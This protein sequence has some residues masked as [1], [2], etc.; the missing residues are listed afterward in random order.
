[1]HEKSESTAGVLRQ[2]AQLLQ[3]VDAN[4][5]DAA[6]RAGRHLVCRP[7]CTQCCYGAFAISPLDARRLHTAMAELAIANPAQA[8][9]LGRRAQE[10]LAQYGPTYPG[11]LLTGILDASAE[12]QAAFEDFANDAACPALD[13]A[14]GLCDV[15]EARPM[16]CRVFGPPVRTAA[17][18]ADQNSSNEEAFAVCEL[19]FTEAAP[20]EIAAAEMVVPY[21]E[22]QRVLV[23]LQQVQPQ[24]AA[25]AETIVAFC[26]LPA[27]PVTAS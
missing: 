20:E 22:E 7:G 24:S 18:M 23:Y 9:I 6:R 1:M 14:T 21:A 2:D 15:Y 17:D 19:C 27:P 3:I 13:P 25:A 10:Y 11:D 5:A 12:G 8:A 16:T 4:L 26:L